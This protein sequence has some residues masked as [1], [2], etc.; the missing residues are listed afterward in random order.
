VKAPESSALQS[1]PPIAIRPAL[2]CAAHAISVAGRQIRMSSNGGAALTEAAIA[3]ILASWGARPCIF[4]F[5]AIK[6]RITGS[7]WTRRRHT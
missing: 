5:S 3:A 2:A 4:Q 6:G 7:D 1:S